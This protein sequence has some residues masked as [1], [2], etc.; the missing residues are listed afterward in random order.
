[1]QVRAVVVAVM[2]GCF[3]C[4]AMAAQQYAEVWNPPEAMK[5][6][7]TAQT[8]K[9]TKTAQRTGGGAHKIAK[10]AIASTKHRG[11][12]HAT[13]HAVPG[14]KPAV[15]AAK[16]HVPAASVQA[17]RKAKQ[18]VASAGASG[19]ATGRPKKVATAP[20]KRNTSQIASRR[21]AANA[22]GRAGSQPPIL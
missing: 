2:V 7:K 13:A 14:K 22:A 18:S 20:V 4:V 21:P 16:A 19:H 5:G 1:M 17:S 9:A 10:P 11:V 6:A 8:A 15:R 12:A 3:S